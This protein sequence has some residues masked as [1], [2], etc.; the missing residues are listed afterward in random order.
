M[1][2]GQLK[3]LNEANDQKIKELSETRISAEGELAE[4]KMT[5]ERLNVSK[6]NLE[7]KNNEL[8]VIM[9]ELRKDEENYVKKE[10]ELR[11]EKE[12][13]NSFFYSIYCYVIM[14]TF[15]SKMTNLENDLRN[16]RQRLNETTNVIN[17]KANELNQVNIEINKLNN[18]I[19]STTT[20]KNVIENQITILAKHGEYAR[21]LSMSLTDKLIDLKYI[22]ESMDDVKVSKNRD[23]LYL[24]LVDSIKYFNENI[25]PINEF[26]NG[27]SLVN[28]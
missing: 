5:A 8:K 24:L 27:Y 11:Q 6:G 18:E 4:L 15:T 3:K 21:T 26:I 2:T 12:D 9:N 10:R 23:R 19:E 17:K 22:K 20:K 16:N 1:V 14:E 25:N 13:C 28:N 7:A